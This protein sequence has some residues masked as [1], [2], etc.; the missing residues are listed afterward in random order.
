L[1]VIGVL[2]DALWGLRDL[3]FVDI[4]KDVEIVGLLL[5]SRCF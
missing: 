5:L 4:C 1:V 2:L 3:I